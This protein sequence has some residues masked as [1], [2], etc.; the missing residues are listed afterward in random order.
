MT[1]TDLKTAVLQ[2]LGVLA[3]NTN[4]NV[5]DTNIVGDKYPSLYAMLL[6]KELV[7][8]STDEDIPDECAIPVTMMLSY[9]CAP[10]FGVVGADYDRLRAEGA[11]DSRPI[12][13]A[14]KQLRMQ[15][16]PAYIASPA[17]PDY[18]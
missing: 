9:L 1:L 8:W 13:I 12:S 5:D 2:H 18:Y 17:Q 7:N 4:P 3:T 11:L 10:S 6:T 14:E 15:M 16:T